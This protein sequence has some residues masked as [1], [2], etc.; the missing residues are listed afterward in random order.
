MTDIHLLLNGFCLSEW[1]INPE[2]GSLTSPTMVTRLEPLL[3]EILL[4]L[5]S[6]EGR[7][8]SKQDLLETVWTGRFVSDET[9]R[10]S[11]YQLRKI[12]GDDSRRPRFIETLPKRGYRML[13]PPVP[14]GSEPPVRASPDR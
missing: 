14:L 7:V 8:V 6:R 11:L 3:M 2:D 10:G 4:L 5:C 1:L 13:V 12:L 9:I